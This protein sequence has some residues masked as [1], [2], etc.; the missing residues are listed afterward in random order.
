MTTSI[1]DSIIG[2]TGLTEREVLLRIAIDLFKEERVT[3]GQA[4]EIAGLHQAEFQKKLAH[5][6]IPIHYGFEELEADLATIDRL[7]LASS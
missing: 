6:R 2:R 4:S 5:R 7:N 3:L 1:P